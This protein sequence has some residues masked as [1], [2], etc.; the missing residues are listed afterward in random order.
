MRF[1][2]LI[3][4]IGCVS[5]GCVAGDDAPSATQPHFRMTV[6]ADGKSAF[7]EVTGCLRPEQLEEIRRQTP[8]LVSWTRFF[9]VRV[10]NQVI[11]GKEFPAIIGRYSLIGDGVRFDPAFPLAPG[12]SCRVD[13]NPQLA[14][15]GKPCDAGPAFARYAVSKPVREQSTFVERV[16]P[17]GED[18][19]EN[20]LRFYIHFSAPMRPGGVYRHIELLNDQGKAIDQ[21]FLEVEEELWDRDAKRLTL[22]IDPGRIKQGLELRERLGPVLEAGK[23]Y[24]L[25]V[26]DTL[27]DANGL[28]LKIGFSKT[29]RAGPG[30]DQCPDPKSW[31]INPP[32]QGTRDALIVRF[33]MPLDRALLGR[34]ITVC[35]RGGQRIAGVITVA[36]GER[37]WQFVPTHPWGEGRFELVVDT[38]LEDRAGNSIAAPFEVDVLHPIQNRI[39]AETVRLQFEITKR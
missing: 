6:P 4:V 20:Q 9:T 7:F 5:T 11:G 8:E 25:S 26:R 1:S 3:A 14:P 21:A 38:R 35:P 18:L 31:K 34:F 24:T 28:P 36:D 29:F 12:V 2:A 13:F 33:P 30:E 15:G 10:E 23:T 19:P 27:I 37:A 16:F 22:F 17:S 32:R 39:E